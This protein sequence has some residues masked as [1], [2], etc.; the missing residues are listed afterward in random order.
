MVVFYISVDHF[1]KMLT[2][3]YYFTALKK[4]V[5]RHLNVRHDS[6]EDIGKFT[7]RESLLSMSCMQNIT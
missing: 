1:L 6:G 7:L 5:L 4:K 2:H 3:N